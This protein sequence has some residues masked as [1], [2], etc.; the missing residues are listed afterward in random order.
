MAK[1]HT[2]NGIEYVKLSISDERALIQ[3][4]VT[5]YARDDLTAVDVSVLD[6]IQ[7]RFIERGSN[8]TR[9]QLDNMALMV[10]ARPDM[11]DLGIELDGSHDTLYGTWVTPRRKRVFDDEIM[12]YERKHAQPEPEPAPPAKE[13]AEVFDLG[14]DQPVILIQNLTINVGR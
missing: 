11:Q 8:V 7:K 3:A 14:D 10:A 9:K 2:A 12:R 1:Q 6:S 5:L 13:A 4:L